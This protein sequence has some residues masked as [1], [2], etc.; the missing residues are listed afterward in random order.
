MLSEKIH[1]VLY[2]K[3][4]KTS[5]SP[6]LELGSLK[7]FHNGCACITHVAVIHGD[8]IYAMRQPNRHHNV[9]HAMYALGIR[10]HE[11]E[12]FLDSNGEYL[13]RLDA[14]DRAEKTEQLKPRL[15]KQ[16]NGPDLYSEDLW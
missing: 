15:P 7:I 13:N 9:L 10:G 5:W 2:Q 16:Y 4:G 14:M 3:N 1:T 6:E 8:V 11:Y 12:G